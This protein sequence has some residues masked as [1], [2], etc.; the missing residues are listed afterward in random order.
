MGRKFGR[1]QLHAEWN[2]STKTDEFF[3]C[4]VGVQ[5]LFENEQKKDCRQNSL[6][7]CIK[8]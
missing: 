3:D 7:V 5:T 1:N 6:C 4:I 8:M 2:T